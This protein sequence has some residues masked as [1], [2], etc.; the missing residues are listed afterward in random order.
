MAATIAYTSEADS[1]DLAP[2]RIEDLLTERRT[3][4]IPRLC[5]NAWADLLRKQQVRSSN[6]RVGSSPASHSEPPGYAANLVAR[7]C[8]NAQDLL[9]ERIHV[10]VSG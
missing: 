5:H 2:A 7:A 10:A 1:Q 3:L 6:L 9:T 8:H 4:A